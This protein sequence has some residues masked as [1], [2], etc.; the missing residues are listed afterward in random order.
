MLKKIMEA[1]SVLRHLC[2]INGLRAL[3]GKNVPL[4]H[5][6]NF[7]RCSYLFQRLAHA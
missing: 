7:R 3:T 1:S 2:A 5:K 4:I 6:G